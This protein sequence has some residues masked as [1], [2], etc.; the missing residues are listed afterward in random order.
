MFDAASHHRA[1]ADAW[2]S[3][4]TITV[5]GT[6][7]PVTG[8]FRDPYGSIAIGGVAVEQPDP[9]LRV[10]EA[11][12]LAIGAAVN[13]KVTVEGTVYTIVVLRAMQQGMMELT[14]RAFA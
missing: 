2:G 9:T 13:D 7:H 14:L 10:T 4:V 1:Q 8:V 6:D 5:G 12:W 3:E 11:D